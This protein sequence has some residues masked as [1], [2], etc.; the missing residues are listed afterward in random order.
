MKKKITTIADDVL[1]VLVTG[2]PSLRDRAL[3]LV[4]AE[5]G[6]RLGEIAELDRTSIAS[7]SHVLPDGMVGVEFL[8]I[9][10]LT[11]ARRRQRRNDRLM[12]LEAGE[13]PMRAT[14]RG[15]STGACYAYLP[16]PKACPIEIAGLIVDHY[17][18]FLDA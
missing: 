17:P 9:C 10:L 15:G 16:R 11:F 14:S 3:I 8:D 2:I 13:P 6:L 18:A 1:A 12:E 4:L 5:S 7:K